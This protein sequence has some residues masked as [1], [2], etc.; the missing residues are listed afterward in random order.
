[1]CISL[2]S[3]KKKVATLNEPTIEIYSLSSKCWLKK[4]VFPEHGGPIKK[5]TSGLIFFPGLD[6]GI[7]GVL[8]GK[9]IGTEVNKRISLLRL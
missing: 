3:Q 4:K 1:M 6:L 2:D 5:I 9:N 8:L 7:N